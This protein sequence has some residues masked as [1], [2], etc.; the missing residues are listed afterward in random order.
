MR[1]GNRAWGRQEEYLESW[2]E[3]R[4]EENGATFGRRS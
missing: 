2:E 1:S 4:V 3:V